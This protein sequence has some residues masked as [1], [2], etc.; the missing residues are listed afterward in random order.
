MH[1][2]LTRAFGGL[3]LQ[4]ISWRPKSSLRSQLQGWQDLKPTHSW[5][6]CGSSLVAKRQPSW[7]PCCGP[8]PG[9]RTSA[10]VIQAQVGEAMHQSSN[11]V[12]DSRALGA[13]AAMG[14]QLISSPFGLPQ[15]SSNLFKSVGHGNPFGNHASY[16]QEAKLVPKSLELSSCWG[17]LWRKGIQLGRRT[18]R[19]SW[20]ISRRH[21]GNRKPAR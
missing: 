21:P 16:C 9:P 12:G 3:K 2:V 14:Q 13:A 19:S 1:I 7:G 15:A 8:P 11:V 6:K 4:I 10:S 17:K 20:S 18:R 5:G